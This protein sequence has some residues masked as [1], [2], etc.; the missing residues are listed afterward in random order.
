VAGQWRYGEIFFGRTVRNWG[1]AP[2]Q[3]LMLGSAPYSYDHLFGRLG[4]PRLNV[5]LLLA[6][7]DDDSVGTLRETQRH[8][9]A[10][11]LSARWRWL[12]VALAESFVYAGVGRGFEPTLA[13]PFTIYALTWRNDQQQGNLQGSASL[14]ARTGAGIFSGELMLDDAQ[15]DRCDVVCEQPAS[16]GLTFTAEGVPFVAG[17]RAFASYTRVAALTYRNKTPAERYTAYGV[18][19]GRAFSDY[20]E[21]RVGADLAFAGMPLR[22]YFSRRRQGEGDYRLREFPPPEEWPTQPG[23]FE[24]AVTNVSRFAVSG[25]AVVGPF[26]VTGDVGYNS[27]PGTAPSGVAAVPA[28]GRSRRVLQGAAAGRCPGAGRAERMASHRSD[29]EP[30]APPSGGHAGTRYG[31]RRGSLAAAAATRT[32]AQLFTDLDSRD[33]LRVASHADRHAGLRRAG[34][35]APAR[36]ERARTVLRPHDFHDGGKV[37]TARGRELGTQAPQEPAVSRITSEVPAT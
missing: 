11:R 18:S 6:R 12:E 35:G 4:T 36:A 16:Y 14:A 5:S 26:D 31:R 24:G 21:F 15:F 32:G 28:A 13:S 7:L 29:D 10:H 1:P 17:Q 3:G 34:A 2:L 27:P 23:I 37:T 19:L 33:D 9:A 8:F 25:G 30:R 22:P 20:D